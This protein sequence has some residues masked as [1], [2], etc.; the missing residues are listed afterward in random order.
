MGSTNFR[1]NAH[2]IDPARR[3]ASHARITRLGTYDWSIP[4]LP[5]LIAAIQ[6]RHRGWWR[7]ARICPLQY[8]LPGP[9]LKSGKR[10]RRDLNLL[11]DFTI[12]VVQ[13]TFRTSYNSKILCPSFICWFSR[14]DVKSCSSCVL[15]LLIL[16]L[17]FLKIWRNFIC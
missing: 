15:I 8:Q 1:V 7:L 12:Y 11:N 4:S 16:F 10:D 17:L 9:L 3:G 6:A 13:R 14:R 5:N 2:T